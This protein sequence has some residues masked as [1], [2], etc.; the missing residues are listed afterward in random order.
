MTANDRA[1]LQE[2]V[3]WHRD[4]ARP[5]RVHSSFVPFGCTME[6]SVG[7]DHQR[8]HT[9][10]ADIL[11]RLL[12]EETNRLLHEVLSTAPEW[13]CDC[14]QRAD[15]GSPHWRWNGRD[16]EHYHGYVIGHVA[17]RHQPSKPSS[18]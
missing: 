5:K 11:E 13:L 3:A 15:A 17:A 8:F 1:T 2:L 12:E 6:A 14:G 10:A 7:S 4:Q 9:R 18:V 16:W